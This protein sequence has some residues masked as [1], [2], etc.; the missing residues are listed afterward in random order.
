MDV[1]ITLN[2]AS[3]TVPEGSTVAQLI[4]ELE[5][6]PEQVAVE[7]NRVVV[8]RALHEDTQLGS[9]DV[10]ELVTLVGGG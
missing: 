5:L 4:R 7:L 8:R 6:S 3:R 2:G 1:K 9:N 10:V